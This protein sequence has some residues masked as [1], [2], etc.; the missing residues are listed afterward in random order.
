MEELI[1][2]EVLVIGSGIAG[3]TTAL[4]LSDFGIPV[5]LVTRAKEPEESNTR[6]AQGGIIFRGE[7]DSPD[8][9]SQD[10][11]AAGVSYSNPKVASILANEGPELVTSVLVDEAGVVFD[12][13]H[14]KLSLHLE[15][16]HSLSRVAHVA[17][18]TGR[19]IELALIK[20]L[21]GRANVR[22]ISS[23]TAV[24]LLTP[25]HH[26]TNRLAVYDRQS[27][28]GAY[29]FDQKSGKVSRILA[30]ET[31]LATGGLGQIFLYTTN[32][33]GSRGDGIAVAN[34]AFARVINLEFVQF[35]PT[36]FVY[37]G[38]PRYLIS[39]AVRG[40]GAR[41]VRADGRPFMEKY[42]P[43]WKDLALRDVVARSIYSEM[44]EAG[45]PNV[46]L[47]LQSYIPRAKIQEHFPNIMAECLKYGIDIT[48]D[49]VPV[50]PAAHYSCGGVWVDEWGR[51]TVERLYAVGEVACT[52]LHGANRLASTSLLEGL[53]FGNRA[54]ISIRDG[55]E[56]L[57]A[58]RLSEIPSWNDQGSGI[59]DPALV[60]QDMSTI[61]QT[62]WNYVGLLRTAPRLERALRE[63]SHL[64][65]EIEQ[66]YRRATLTDEVLGL[67]N[68]VRTANLLA[69][70]AWE[71]KA[72]IGCHYRE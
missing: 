15:G 45:V 59:P 24:D 39:E 20:T 51:T 8:L 52:G 56:G 27:C 70:A 38:A 19:E 71:N 32:P 54:A 50:A 7:G 9:L 22:I 64:E 40:E 49:L 6:Y 62:M 16:G 53:V 44:L 72:S 65:T 47:D 21:K 57:S 23:A 61:Q 37:P 28:V 18:A 63:L 60:A 41:L 5:V 67:R 42:S 48:T 1:E 29:V 55:L 34:R 26:S 36:A 12:R 3:G 69:L 58:P 66:F 14:G 35:H 10:I 33:V 30:K 43:K 4:K 11:I 46:Y 31:V 2:T 17:D 13:N 25:S 68:A